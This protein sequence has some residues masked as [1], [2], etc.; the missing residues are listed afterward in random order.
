MQHKRAELNVISYNATISACENAAQPEQATELSREMQRER[1][2][3]NVVSYN[4]TIS[5][6]EN[7]AQ[8]K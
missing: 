4:S 1:M 8:P 3:L 7:A 6:C 2:K 5:A